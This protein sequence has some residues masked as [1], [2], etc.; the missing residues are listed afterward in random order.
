MLPERSAAAAW[1]D[2][3]GAAA[4]LRYC[5]GVSVAAPIDHLVGRDELLVELDRRLESG[6]RCVTLHGPPGVG[7]TQLAL[8]WASRFCGDRD[9]VAVVSAVGVDHPDDFAVSVA[10]A[11][12]IDAPATAAVLG[13]R[14]A[15]LGRVALVVDECETATG[16]LAP[17]LADW[18]GR[19]P[20]LVVVA[21][22]QA[23]LGH[24]GEVRF[25]VAPL[26]VADAVALLRERARAVEAE[27]A[28]TSS[29]ALEALV[30]ELDCLPLALELAAAR[31]PVFTPA[32]LLASLR[33]S[34]DRF[35]LLQRD[36][37]AAASSVSLARA[38]EQAW[39]GLDD[40]H[41]R[42]LAQ[43]SVFGGS[44]SR[45]AAAAVVDVGDAVWLP[46]ALDRL[47]RRSLLSSRY[48]AD[49]DERRF[50]LLSC[51]R[52]F[53]A[54]RLEPDAADDLAAG[55]ARYFGQRALEWVEPGFGPRSAAEAHRLAVESD[56]LA[57]ASGRR[58]EP[59]AA[60]ASA[61]A[62]EALISYRRRGG[63]RLEPADRALAAAD[64]SGSVSL[65][66]R[67]RLARAGALHSLA[68]RD[69][70]LTAAAEAHEL[71][72]SHDGALAAA[73]A[74][75]AGRLAYYLGDPVAAGA[76]FDRAHQAA[77]ASERA[78]G[79]A[80]VYHGHVEHWDQGPTATTLSLLERGVEALRRTGD[81]FGRAHG[82]QC[83]AIALLDAGRLDEAEEHSL[84]V[85]ALDRRLGFRA[86]LK[87]ALGT[88]G[89]IA[90]ERGDLDR[91]R[92]R[93]SEAIGLARQLGADFS[94]GLYVG[95]QGCATF[96]SGDAQTALALLDEAVDAFERSNDRRHQVVYARYAA[97]VAAWH[98]RRL[99]DR[100]AGLAA[101]RFDFGGDRGLAL[102]MSILSRLFAA[103]REGGSSKK[104]RA[105]RL[106][107]DA[108]VADDL[109]QDAG[110][111]PRSWELR[112]A[113]A[114]LARA[115]AEAGAACP[116]EVGPN[117]AWF[118]VDGADL[119]DLSGQ[120]LLGRLLACLGTG[121]SAL[122][123]VSADA[124]IA[125]G[126]PSERMRAD[127]AAARLHSA[128]RRLR[129]LGLEAYLR[130]NRDGYWLEG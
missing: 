117:G 79:H 126:W 89:L 111:A 34:A 87:T 17:L 28:G 86:G 82:Q 25:E 1:N 95:Y 27:P 70:A 39:T 127:A 6:S 120:P 103:L 109:G 24:P 52:E 110:A 58:G 116:V 91:A 98:G 108:D 114:L 43:L 65:R 55:H 125:A 76:W 46:D 100:L 20:S 12:A 63:V 47:A 35:R 59:E 94:F 99:S 112:H 107:V 3:R 106:A 26:A 53:A 115:E 31:L 14:I 64:A 130:S 9:A 121:S 38:L 15:G 29:G 50:Y 49:L 60:A 123:P 122:E 37:G 13:E 11:L 84:E 75:L 42:V 81:D 23:V 51:V 102:A 66:A 16:W 90:H 77:G 118:R 93:Y 71:A 105:L 44:F 4:P 113:L 2:G 88:L 119:V 104:L 21:T 73:C 40:V 7:K 22:S 67:A 68:R 30:A 48:D 33:S 129:R 54:G 72:V 62:L 57:R 101:E 45:A 85:K 74:T 56:N 92:E 19:A 83:L 128:I 36:A 18:L 78:A 41:R 96:E 69:E 8:T 80:R 32:E 124:L 61:L 10:A 97:L 5:G